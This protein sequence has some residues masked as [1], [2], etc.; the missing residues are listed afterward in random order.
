MPEGE[1]PRGY[2]VQS[3]VLAARLEELQRQAKIHRRLMAREKE[4]A[5]NVRSWAG[6]RGKCL[7]MRRQSFVLVGTDTRHVDILHRYI[8]P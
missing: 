2:V 6:Y 7:G 1:M 5:V 8:T 4:P 3:T